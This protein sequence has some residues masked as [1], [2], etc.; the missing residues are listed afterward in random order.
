APAATAMPAAAPAAAVPSPPPAAPSFG[1]YSAEHPKPPPASPSLATRVS[2]VAHNAAG[3]M[4]VTLEGGALWELMD[5]ADPLLAAGDAVF[6][7]RASFGSYLMHT[8]SAR[9]HRIRR[10]R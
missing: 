5:E 6:I 4:T 8:P 2:S 3:H 1:L 7:T 9:V 10:L